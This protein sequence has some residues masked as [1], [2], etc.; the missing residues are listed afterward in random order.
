MPETQVYY[1]VKGDPASLKQIQF[2]HHHDPFFAAVASAAGFEQIAAALMGEPACLMNVQY[3]NKPPKTN[4][5][6]PAHQDGFYFHIKP[7]RAVTMW[8]ALDDADLKNGCLVYVRGSSAKGLRPHQASGV[9]GFSQKCTD[10]GTKADLKAELAMVASPGDLVA[11][12][13]MMLHRAGPNTT[14]G[15]SR[16]AVGF[17][18]YAASAVP[19]AAKAAAYQQM[20]NRQLRAAGMI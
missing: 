5:A 11:H 8:L 12:D 19:D 4:L 15:K 10:Y 17:I 16:R 1:D 20:I 6:T 7:N 9:L 2:L 3:F 18:Y 13:S 14:K